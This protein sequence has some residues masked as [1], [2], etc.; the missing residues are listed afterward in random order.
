LPENKDDIVI[1]PQ[2]A[3]FISPDL[4]VWGKYEET[5]SLQEKMMYKTHWGTNYGMQEQ[6]GGQK[7]ATE[8]QF[9]K[10][11]LENRL[12]QY[13]DNA[14]FIEWTLAEWILNFFDLKKK[15]DESKVTINLGRRYTIESY[16]AILKQYEESKKA[17]ENTVILD[18]LS[19]PSPILHIAILLESK[20]YIPDCPLCIALI[21][22]FC[23]P[24]ILDIALEYS[25]TP[26]VP[27][28]SCP[29][30]E[31]LSITALSFIDR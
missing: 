16:D 13:A 5:Q 3:G 24:Y 4:E 10:Q 6:V 18:K 22:S 30:S 21:D 27:S 1:A 26:P 29:L 9:D 14:E 11:P 8:V 28:N 19:M 7:T 15:R 2:I 31:L 25:R 20:K 17:G 12:N 23:N